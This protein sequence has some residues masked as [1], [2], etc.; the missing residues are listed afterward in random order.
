[1]TLTGLTEAFLRGAN[2]QGANLENANLMGTNLLDT[3]LK[4][5]RLKGVCYN[6]G[7]QW[8]A[9]FDPRSAGAVPKSTV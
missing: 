6:A 8:P 3:K 7:T 4:G 5:A 1:L 9:G 2:L